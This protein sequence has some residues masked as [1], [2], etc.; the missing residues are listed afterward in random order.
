[1][2]TGKELRDKELCTKISMRGGIADQKIGVFRLLTFSSSVD[3]F[4]CLQ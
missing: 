4:Y 2:W 3:K 1:M